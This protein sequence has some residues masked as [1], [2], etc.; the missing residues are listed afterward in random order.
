M[1]NALDTKE[2]SKENPNS[3]TNLVLK[4]G[5][6]LLKSKNVQMRRN[7]A[8]ELGRLKHKPAVP[9]LIKRLEDED[10]EVRYFV[11]QALGKIGDS[12]AV[13]ALRSHLHKETDIDAFVS[14][15]Y[16]LAKFDDLSMIEV[17]ERI[18]KTSRYFVIRSAAKEALKRIKK[19]RQ[20]AN[21][22]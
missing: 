5:I 13:P 19:R 9:A 16:A 7:V 20:E 14:C 4:E 17:L 15:I 2:A 18:A 11:A 22:S 6:M 21:S 1:K 12:V 8:D 3:F 10:A